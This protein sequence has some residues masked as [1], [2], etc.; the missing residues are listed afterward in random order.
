MIVRSNLPSSVLIPAACSYK[1]VLFS[2]SQYIASSHHIPEFVSVKY[3]LDLPVPRHL[4]QIAPFSFHFDPIAP[5]VTVYHYTVS[6]LSIRNVIIVYAIVATYI[7]IIPT[8]GAYI[9]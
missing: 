2:D 8:A 1:K 4:E 7:S 5:Q 9:E 3:Q 6:L